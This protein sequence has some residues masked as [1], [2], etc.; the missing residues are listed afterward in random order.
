MSNDKSV[1]SCPCCS[2]LSYQQC[3]GRF[4]SGQ[5]TPDTAEQLM[6]SRYSA[7]SLGLIDYL[8]ATIH[9]DS[10]QNDDTQALQQTIDQTKWLG[11]KIISQHELGA[12]QVQVEFA[13]FYQDDNNIGQLHERSRFKYIN[14]RWYYVDGEFLPPLKLGRN[15]ACFCGSGKKFKQCHQR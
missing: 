1:S 5:E 10:R 7:F 15:E 2:G 9:A 12:N 4:H 13:A 8:L 3:C 14:Q 11:L 6:R